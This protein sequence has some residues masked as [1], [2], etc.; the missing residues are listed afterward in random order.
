MI[1][2]NPPFFIEAAVNYQQVPTHSAALPVF[3]FMEMVCFS[4]AN[5]SVRLYDFHLLP[6]ERPGI[7]ITFTSQGF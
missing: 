3:E 6:M 2:R 7:L 1:S 5:F 4:P